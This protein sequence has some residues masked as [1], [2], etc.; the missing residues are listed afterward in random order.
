MEQGTQMQIPIDKIHPSKVY[1]RTIDQAKLKE[2]T[3]SIKEQGVM[4]PIMLRPDK[5]GDGYEI[6]YGERR[7][8]GAKDA[9]LETVP[10]EIRILTDDQ[11]LEMALIENDQREDANPMEQAMGYKTA[12]DR[13]QHT[14]ETLALKFSKKLP[15]ILGRLKLLEIIKPAQEALLAGKIEYGHALLLTRLKNDGDQK[16]LFKKI[17]A[18]DC[19]SHGRPLTVA[20]AQE[21]IDD[22]SLRLA[23]A[24]FDVKQC[25]TCGF[26][27]KAQSVLFPET[28]KEDDECMDRSCFF[29]KT[30]E[31]YTKLAKDLKENGIKVLTTAK[32]VQE[33]RRAANCCEISPDPKYT[34]HPKKYKSMCLP[35]G[36]KALFF[37]EEGNGPRKQY[38][39]GEICLNKKC[40][41]TM[42]GRKEAAP[43]A[44]EAASSTRARGRAAEMHG[45]E[46]RDRFL[47]ARVPA[48]VVESETLQLRLAL[49]HALCR[50]E[51]FT[52]AGKNELKK[53]PDEIQAEL[54]REFY[55]GWKATASLDQDRLYAAIA[56]I[57]PD[58]VYGI[59]LKTIVAGTPYL[60]E[61]VLLQI[62]P[63]AKIDMKKDFVI[64]KAYLET[65]T[66][67]E[68]IK[69]TADLG[70]QGKKIPV[71]MLDKPRTAPIATEDMKKPDIIKA[72]LS[73][74][75]LGKV[76]AEIT[77]QCKIITIEATKAK[78]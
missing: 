36:T 28:A 32:E 2:L 63:E 12:M 76:P 35:C 62:T 38:E 3:A 29:L 59:L 48:K 57:R 66:K 18:G 31:H 40:F 1:R 53:D 26:R 27:S 60:E 75:L 15:F 24:P 16:E 5:D 34:M 30:R 58:K 8:T 22:F 17:M 43:S 9:G 20:Q 64:D 72:I 4:Q 45:E 77:K 65:K 46:C 10:A 50:F 54:I 33:A 11:A 70:I 7:W 49:L 71:G 37:Y 67:A 51:K 68:L 41:N 25:A 55:P 14:P 74:N 6:V 52:K 21:E 69:L 42:A 61:D 19:Y 13:G 39:T 23:S 73:T 47:R 44:A 78:K 56:G